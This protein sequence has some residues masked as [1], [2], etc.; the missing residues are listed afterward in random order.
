MSKD[1]VDLK[2]RRFLTVATATVGGVGAGLA[3]WPF[4]SAWQPSARARAA[5][6]P[7]HYDTSKMELGQKITVSWRGKPVWI[8][9]RSPEM[10]A[11]LDEV[12]DRLRDPGCEE[13]QQPAYAKN[14]YRAIREP[15]LVMVA[16]CTHLGCVPLYEPDHPNPEID[17]HW[18][19]GF[20]C[21]C[22]GS[23]YDLSGR[24]YSG[25]PAPLNMPVPQYHWQGNVVV[26]GVD[27][28]EN[29]AA[30][31]P[32]NTASTSKGAA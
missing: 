27:P 14:K 9:R 1:G 2:K 16:I 7:A 24:V 29:A 3:A 23:K 32:G 20:F 10:L 12:A 13:D 6:A 4:V 26:V 25:V 15:W 31:K 11:T 17:N 5:G 28:P 30:P 19:G 22:H 18:M 8:I 21:P